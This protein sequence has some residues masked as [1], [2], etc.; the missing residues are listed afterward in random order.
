MNPPSH[1][2]IYPVLFGLAALLVC[3][4]AQA[5]KELKDGELTV[6]K[7][8]VE[9]S[10]GESKAPA[11][12][13][14]KLEENSLVDT[15]ANSFTEMQFAEGSVM[16]L[17]SGTRFTFQS[18]ERLIKL[19]EGALLIHTPPGNGGISVDGGGVVGAV[20]GSTVMASRD[21]AGNFSFLVL[22]ST[23]SGRISNGSGASTEIRPGQIAFF[24]KAQVSI[25]VY[26]ANLDS[27]IDYSPL[28]TQFPKPMPGIDQVQEMA[29]NQVLEVM[30]EVKFIVGPR[31]LGIE[32]A[33]MAN[34][35]FSLIFEKSRE[36]I[37]AAK[38]LL[39]TDL[40]TAAGKEIAAGEGN[41]GNLLLPP[42]SLADARQ[43]GGSEIAQRSNPPGQVGNVNT[44]AGK[45]EDAPEDTDTA[46]GGGGG[47]DTQPPVAPVGGGTQVSSPA[48][49]TQR[50]S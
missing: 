50:T 9:Y 47:A 32:S 11:K 25:R 35:L 16:R 48:T 7:N 10:K 3:S 43:P 34:D 19:E 18:K 20:S 31:D 27:F 12:A 46:A 23:T 37:V 39:L 40:S 14:E 49:P 8:Q 15:G 24:L 21:R 36:Q 28:F 33:D 38:N 41:A 45:D 6:V 44:A 17:G 1:P 29:G 22:E 4:L 26:E 5:A 30:N 42:G 13:N 2:K